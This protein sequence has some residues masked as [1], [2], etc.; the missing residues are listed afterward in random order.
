MRASIVGHSGAKF[1]PGEGQILAKKKPQMKGL[2]AA[3]AVGVT[4][5]REDGTGGRLPAGNIHHDQTVITGIPAGQK[6]RRALRAAA[7]SC[8]GLDSRTGFYAGAGPGTPRLSAFRASS[9]GCA[10]E[11]QGASGEVARRS[12]EDEKPEKKQRA[13]VR[14]FF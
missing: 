2:R 14:R 6:V 4:A 3:T 8:V 5:L 13:F 9:S 12:G 10:R 7:D 11:Q 1:L